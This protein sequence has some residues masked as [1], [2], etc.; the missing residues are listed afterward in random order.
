M[1]DVSSNRAQPKIMN[2]P[3]HFQAP[4]SQSSEM[5]IIVK[6]SA[7]HGKG[8]FASK[9]IEKNQLI[10]TYVGPRVDEDGIYVLWIDCEVDGIYG[11]DGRNDLKFTNHSATPNASFE[12]PELI[13]LRAIAPDEEITF[14]YGADWA[15]EE[16]IDHEG[17]QQEL[18]EC[19]VETT[20]NLREPEVAKPQVPLAT[21]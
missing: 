3:D 8:V 7:I 14:H 10:G 11:I 19:L 2:V 21:P 17:L 15:E 18:E 12:G 9:S 4:D 13:A 6:E 20:K 5:P 1:T 16:S